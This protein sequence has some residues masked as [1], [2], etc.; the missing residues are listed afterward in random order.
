MPPCFLAY[1]A[2]G[3]QRPQQT[4]ARSVPRV[5]AAENIGRVDKCHFGADCASDQSELS[6][7]V[8]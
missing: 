4:R 7:R 2:T 5:T 1:H 3:N 6:S 8:P